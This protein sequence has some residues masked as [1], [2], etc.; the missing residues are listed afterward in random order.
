MAVGG[1]APA[2][3]RMTIENDH[4]AAQPRTPRRTPGSVGRIPS[5]ILHQPLHIFIPHTARAIHRRSRGRPAA[6]AKRDK[7][8]RNGTPSS[9]ASLR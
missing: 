9:D 2:S 7:E 8:T 6:K 1:I 4:M 5:R 3:A